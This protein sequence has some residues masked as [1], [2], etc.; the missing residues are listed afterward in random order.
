MLRHDPSSVNFFQE[1]DMMKPARKAA[2]ALLAIGLA[3]CP[4]LWAD[5]NT[6]QDRTRT[7]SKVFEAVKT[8]ERSTKPQPAP[9]PTSSTGVY[10]SGAATLDHPGRL[11]ASNCF[12]CHGTNGHGME[13]L[14]GKSA[15]S[16]SSELY[17]MRLKPAASH[18]MNVHAQGY[19]TSQ[20]GLIAD[21]FSKQQP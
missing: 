10:T 6:K 11:L 4:P 20:I 5:G 12:Q 1:P 16:I 14:A 17:E 2:V 15:S 9:T 8:S 18:I 7:L 13:H 19:T 21:Y 3:A